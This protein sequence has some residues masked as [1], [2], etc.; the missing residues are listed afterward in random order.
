MEELRP[1]IDPVCKKAGPGPVALSPERRRQD[2]SLQIIAHEHR[3][4]V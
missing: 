3:E 2:R 4:L 1:D